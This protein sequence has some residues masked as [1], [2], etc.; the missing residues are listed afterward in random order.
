LCNQREATI[1]ITTTVGDG[2]G[3]L[4]AGNKTEMHV[5]EQCVLGMTEP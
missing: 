1:Q 3:G 2:P 4:E 5:C